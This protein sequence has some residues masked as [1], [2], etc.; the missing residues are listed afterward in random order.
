[1]RYCSTDKINSKI[2]SI[3]EKYKSSRG[4]IYKLE[5]ILKQLKTELN[6]SDEEY[7]NLHVCVGEIFINAVYHGNRFDNNKFVEVMVHATDKEIVVSITD[8]GNGFEEA[9]V[10]NPLDEINLLKDYGRGIFIVRKY[11]QKVVLKQSARG[12]CVEFTLKI[13]E[14]KKA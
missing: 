4:T 2:I 12:F 9:N 6:L 7:F 5:S 8:E 11:S 3:Y 14:Q 10:I 13:G 1:M